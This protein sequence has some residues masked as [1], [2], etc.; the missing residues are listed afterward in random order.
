VADTDLTGNAAVAASQRAQFQLL[1]RNGMRANLLT[2]TRGTEG[3]AGAGL[4]GATPGGVLDVPAVGSGT[5]SEAA[6][7][8]IIA[9]TAADAAAAERAAASAAENERKR[10]DAEAG[11]G[12]RNTG[13]T[14]D[15]D[16][17][18]TA[19]PPG[20]RRDPDPTPLPGRGT[21]DDEYDPDT[22]LRLTP[23]QK[24]AKKAAARMGT[25]IGE[26]P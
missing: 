25:I 16:G 13:P 10:Q 23:A 22:G 4:S 11:V 15:R 3:V 7:N 1:A 6:G 18:P 24:A 9:K 8:A 26:A 20:G 19:P 17:N 12:W 21:G 5:V 14:Q 2:S